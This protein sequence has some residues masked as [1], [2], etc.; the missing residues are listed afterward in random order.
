[1]TTLQTFNKGFADVSQISLQTQLDSKTEVHKQ[2]SH[3][4]IIT[5]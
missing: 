1:M 2:I 5:N 4:K 3:A